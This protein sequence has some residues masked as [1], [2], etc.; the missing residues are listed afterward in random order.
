MKRIIT[1]FVFIGILTSCNSSD[2]TKTT[3]TKTSVT[4][5]TS[6]D[7]NKQLKPIDTD[8]ALIATALMAAPEESRSK[9]KVIGYNMAGEFVTL[10][11]GNNEFI[12]LA[13]DPNKDGFS[14]ACYHK[15]LEPFMARGRALRAEGKTRQEV[16]AIRGAEMESGKLKITTGS[17]LH[18]YYG[19]KTMYDPETSK[20]DGA[21]LRYVI[22]M[23][24]ATSESTGLPKLPLA[25]NHP[26]IMNPGTPRAH[27]MISPL[28]E[29]RE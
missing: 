3:A 18:I 9:S 29:D 19:S 13:D 16:F 1:A 4:E 22:Y 26:W 25:P 21:Q 17:T 11:E 2:K 14:A 10:R 12:V 5:K 28:P 27:I 8:E 7:I 15:D 20:V 6:N 23:P 24:W